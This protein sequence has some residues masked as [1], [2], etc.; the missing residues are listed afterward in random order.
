MHGIFNHSIILHPF[1][2]CALFVGQR[3]HPSRPAAFD[4]R[5]QAAG[6]WSHSVRLQ[7]PEGVDPSSRP[8]PERRWQEAQEEDLHHPQEDQAQEKEGQAFCP[9]VLQ[10]EKC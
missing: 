7:H 6:G 10:G 4:L 1:L 8:P 5:W 2:L 9:Q 3:G